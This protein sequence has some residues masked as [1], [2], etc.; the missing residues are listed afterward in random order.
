MRLQTKAQ[1][2]Q[3]QA[4]QIA[5]ETAKGASLETYKDLKIVTRDEHDTREYYRLLV[6]RAD[7]GHPVINEYHR[8]AESR[9]RKIEGMK[10]NTDRRETYKT[11]QKAKGRQLTGAAQAAAAIREELKTKF[12]GVKFSVTSDNFSMGNSVHISWTDG[13][14][15]DEVSAITSKYQYGH[16]NGM[17]DIYEYSNSR[18]DIP[19]AKYVSEHRKQSEETRAAID[20]AALELWPGEDWEQKRHRE[21]ESRAIFN[22]TALPI[23][24]KVT[25]IERGEQATRYVDRLIIEAPEGQAEAAPVEVPAGK[26]QII[27]YSEKAIAIISAENL[28]HILGRDGL[29]LKFNK[30]LTCG[31]AWIAP[32]SK[33][34]EITKA[35][36]A[37][38]KPAAVQAPDPEEI[39]EEPTPEEAAQIEEEENGHEI[40]TAGKTFATYE[41]AEREA[42]LKVRAEAMERAGRQPSTWT[43]F[44]APQKQ[45]EKEA[46]QKYGENTYKDEPAP[47]QETTVRTFHNLQDIEEA[48]NSGEVI[49]L[50]NLHELVNKKTARVKEIAAKV[51][52]SQAA[53]AMRAAAEKL[54]TMADEQSKKMQ[55]IRAEIAEEVQ[56]IKEIGTSEDGFFRVS[57]PTPASIEARRIES[58][59]RKAGKTNTALPAPQMFINF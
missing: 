16:F 54:N 34:E 58:D 59:S 20:A 12:K 38:S 18:E 37:L 57:G 29:G 5:N 13:P 25:G 7:A 4:A 23:G 17:E 22:R 27:D 55:T 31:P 24:A 36:Q 52:P 10:A 33:L 28:A 8:T 40:V 56:K 14:T 3:Y 21:Q 47:L 43:S 15:E 45:I 2:T 46:G 48:A 6:F 44:A 30:Y 49:S 9:A 41:E 42:L 26:I 35:L 51:E 19:Q 53:A 32:K 11:E 1:R 50:Y 39:P